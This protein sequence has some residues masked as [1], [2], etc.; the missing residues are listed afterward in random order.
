LFEKTRINPDGSTLGGRGGLCRDDVFANVGSDTF[1]EGGWDLGIG[2]PAPADLEVD[3]VDDVGQAR[4][5]HDITHLDPRRRFTSR[6]RSLH[7]RSLRRSREP[8][9]ICPP[10]RSSPHSATTAERQPT[11]RRLKDGQVVAGGPLE[12]RA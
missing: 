9:H 10:V 6:S 11:P 7:G 2:R 8:R 3:M 5:D 4:R 12:D 1:E